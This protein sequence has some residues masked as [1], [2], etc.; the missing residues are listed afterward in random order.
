[1]TDALLKV[2]GM[3][4]QQFRFGDFTIDTGR[5]SLTRAG[6]AV[7]LRPKSFAL[8]EYLVRHAGTLVG[9][10][11]LLGAVWAGVVV[12]D[13][14]LTRCISEVRTALSDSSQ[15]IIKTVARRGYLFDAPLDQTHSAPPRWRKHKYVVPALAALVVAVAALAISAVF[16][17]Q[18][19][20][21]ERLTL[22]VLPFVSLG[23]DEGQSELADAITDELTGA[24]ARG[25]SLH[26]I[27]TGTALTFKG[28]PVD[29]RRV[30]TDIGVRY[31][32]EGSVQRVGDR[33]RIGAR[34]VD[35]ATSANLWAEQFDVDRGDRAK[36]QDE[37]VLRLANVLD[38]EV[39]RAEGQRAIVTPQAEDLALKCVAGARAQAGE[40]RER[41][42]AYC[43]QALKQDPRNVRAL[44]QLAT[45]HAGRVSRGQT[46]EP[47]ADLAA[48]AQYAALALDVAPSDSDA[49]CA[50]ASVLE[51]ERQL[52]A[53]IAEAQRCL[54]LNPSNANAYRELAI[55]HFFL[56]EP[57]R[58]LEYADRGMLLSPRD[59]R[60]SVF[61][62]FKGWALLQQNNADEAL[63]WLR[64]AQTVQ[65]DSPNILLALTVA[66]QQTGRDEEARSTMANY[67]G[68]KRTRA[69]TIEQFDHRPDP[70]LAFAS[71]AERTNTSLR[72]AGMPER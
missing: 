60:L 22:I 71:F 26:V 47:A 40:L 6:A 1:M 14:S 55:Q 27:A 34:L 5:G 28:T 64:R 7:A 63:V 65:P 57:A 72:K 10:E 32:V 20:P 35:T 11:E 53:A 4:G 70:N 19:P 23:P 52:R 33:L 42:L 17:G 43:E 29:A 8:L 62:L 56:V 12:T 51:G 9:K 30:G 2:Q 58:T 44:V 54:E 21:P 36:V 39:V 3:A 49:H 18:R 69:R 13:D 46:L 59:P 66:V 41:S 15:Q 16:V 50:Q 67:L 48:A 61:L 37:I 24:L 31:A 45:A 38:V 68:L 25:R